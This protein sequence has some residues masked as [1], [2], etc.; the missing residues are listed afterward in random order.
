[1]KRHPARLVSVPLLAGLVLP[2]VL[3]QAAARDCQA[4]LIPDKNL[5]SAVRQQIFDKRDKPDELTEE[6]LKKVNFLDGTGKGIK[7][8]TG[9][10]KCTNLLE[11][12][13]AKNEIVDVGPLKD[14]KGLQSLD[15]SG[16]KIVDVGPLGELVKL[17]YLHLG[18]NQIVAVEPLAK[19]K[20]LNFLD[21]G[22]NKIVDPAPLS[23]L[24]RLSTFDLSRNQIADLKG[25]TNLDLV[26]TSLNLSD[27][28]LVDLGP[29]GKPLSVRTLQLQRNKVTDLAPLLAAAKADAEG[30]RR[31]APYLRLYLEG[32]PLSEAAK[33]EQVTQLKAAGVK[34]DPK[35][36]R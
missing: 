1:M 30:E 20:A 2:F 26:S 19:L 31:F 21:L 7:D 29:L 10:E 36:S 33:G 15:L 9:L 34:I 3:V 5:E 25:L 8:L 13:L 6:E 4:G 14:I 24:P 12:K 18:G 23:A 32:N 28:Q 22:G 27:N 35:E 17:Q 16:N 11:V